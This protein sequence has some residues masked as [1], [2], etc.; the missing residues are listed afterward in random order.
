MSVSITDLIA[1]L[2]SNV[3][4]LEAAERE[5]QQAEDQANNLAADVVQL[6]LKLAALESV[7][8]PTEPEWEYGV[9]YQG[10]ATRSA[11]TIAGNEEVARKWAAGSPSGWRVCRRTKGTRAGDWQPV[12]LSEA[13]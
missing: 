13:E 7:T 1:Q 11:F 12:P 10:T 6:E 9:E 8:V 4:A 5:I 3:D 2:Q